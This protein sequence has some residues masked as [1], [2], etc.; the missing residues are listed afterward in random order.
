MHTHLFT[1]CSC[2]N[3]PKQANLTFPLVED[4]L[5]LELPP[6]IQSPLDLGRR[7]VTRFGAVEEVTS[8]ALLHELSTSVAR[9]LT[10]AIRAVD[11]GVQRLHLGVSQNK[12]TVCEGRGEGRK[13]K[14][15]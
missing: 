9:E 14:A 7:P 12:V 13:K 4:Q 1:L 11:D 8:T 15:V 5:G 10:E 3:N 2:H 6:V